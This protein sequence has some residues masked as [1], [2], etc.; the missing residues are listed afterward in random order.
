M[1]YELNPIPSYF[2]CRHSYVETHAQ[3]SFLFFQWFSSKCFKYFESN[4]LWGETNSIN[5]Q[6][7][8]KILKRVRKIE[9]CFNEIEASIN[10]LSPTSSIFPSPVN[11]AHKHITFCNIS[12]LTSSWPH[13]SATHSLLLSISLLLYTLQ[14]L[15]EVL[16]WL[17]LSSLF[18]NLMN[19][20]WWWFYLCW[21]DRSS[22]DTNN[23][24]VAQ[25]SD[26]LNWWSVLVV[27]L[28]HHFI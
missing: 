2:A 10:L 5:H 1:I 22:R 24:Q 21:S 8:L 18:H 26:L 13:N 4:K 16:Y 7:L 17:L 12:R 15:G 27:V 25:S 9:Y 6:H 23:L 19:T 20:F 14:C 28:S 11:N 3:C